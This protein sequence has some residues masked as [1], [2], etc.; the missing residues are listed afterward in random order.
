[1][2]SNLN[3]FVLGRLVLFKNKASERKFLNFA[4]R[5]QGRILEC[6]LSMHMTASCVYLAYAGGRHAFSLCPLKKL[7]RTLIIFW[8]R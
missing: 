4:I 2:V 3:F 1:M 5:V 8:V 7:R 6:I